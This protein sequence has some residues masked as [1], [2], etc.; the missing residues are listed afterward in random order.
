MDPCRWWLCFVETVRKNTKS[1]LLIHIIVHVVLHGEELVASWRV[2][3]YPDV[4]VQKLVC[5][6]G[7]VTCCEVWRLTKVTVTALVD[8]RGIFSFPFSVSDA[9]LDFSSLPRLRW[10]YFVS[11]CVAVF[12][13]WNL[14]PGG[15]V[16]GLEGVLFFY[17]ATAHPW[18]RTS[19]SQTVNPQTWP[20]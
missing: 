14:Q 3:A 11:F 20:F 9:Q 18:E 4:H 17:E 12:I 7:I 15:W 16:N 1:S 13:F 2:W 19:L 6:L 5:W 8:S 10:R